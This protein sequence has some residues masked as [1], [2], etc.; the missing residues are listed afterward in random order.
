MRFKGHHR[1]KLRIT[2][3]AEGDELMAD[4]L[5]DDEYLYQIY[6]QNDPALKKYLDMGLSP[7]LARTMTLF[8]DLRDEYHCCSMDNL[9]NSDAF[10]RHAYNN[11]NKVLVHGFTCKWGK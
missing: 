7:L 3:K 5:C 6:F 1:D 9:Y 2:F 11:N 10:F 4:A 8:D